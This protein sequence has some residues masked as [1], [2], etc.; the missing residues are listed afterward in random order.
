MRAPRRA[1]GDA[2]APTKPE[3]AVHEM[4]GMYCLG[5]VVISQARVPSVSDLAAENSP[6]RGEGASVI[7]LWSNERGR[8]SLDERSHARPR[9][10]RGKVLPEAPAGGI[11]YSF[12]PDRLLFL[13]RD[14]SFAPLG[15]APSGGIVVFTATPRQAVRAAEK[16]QSKAA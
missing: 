14:C 11:E 3:A 13:H 12:G 2:P 9:T 5:E 6:L 8:I 1:G 10:E 16:G 4:L 15:P 7:A